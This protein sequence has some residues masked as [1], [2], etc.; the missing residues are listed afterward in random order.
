VRGKRAICRPPP[1][2]LALASFVAIIIMQGM[3]VQASGDA[4]AKQVREI[5]RL[6]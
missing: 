2:R 1:T 4:T 5:A 6:D 3:A